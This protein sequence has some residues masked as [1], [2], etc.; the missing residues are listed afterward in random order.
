MSAGLKS[1]IT[2][3]VPVPPPALPPRIR[4]GLRPR[5]NPPER[6]RWILSRTSHRTIPGVP[7]TMAG[8]SDTTRK[9]QTGREDGSMLFSYIFSFVFFR[10][11]CFSEQFRYLRIS[12][13]NP[14]GFRILFQME[15][16]LHFAILYLHPDAGHF[17]FN[18]GIKQKY[19][20]SSSAVM[21]RMRLA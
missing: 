3:S 8:T 7:D 14:I 17:F 20:L 2:A 13:R 9:I 6:H 18:R 1:R 4:P 11:L 10:F 21:E 12:I 15:V 19:N 16:K 5:Y